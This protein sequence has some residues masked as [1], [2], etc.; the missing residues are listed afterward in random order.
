MPKTSNLTFVV[1][2]NQQTLGFE[3]SFSDL[4]LEGDDEVSWES[5]SHQDGSVISESELSESSKAKTLPRTRNT[6]RTNKRGLNATVL[7]QLLIDIE[8]AG[9]LDNFSLAR[10]FKKRPVFYADKSIQSKARYKVAH[11]KTLPRQEFN[12]ILADNGISSPPRVLKE[13]QSKS[14]KKPPLPLKSTRGALETPSTSPNPK[15]SLRSVGRGFP[16]NLYSPTEPPIAS[17]NPLHSVYKTPLRVKQPANMSNASIDP[18]EVVKKKPSKVAEMLGEC[19]FKKEA[20]R[21]IAH[22]HLQ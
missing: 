6:F 3:E 18:A 2:Q 13:I 16:Q 10:A 17:R 4:N 20:F 8:T 9:G 19:R 12:R 21:K 5:S 7:K 22:N 1:P 15:P 14:S 11:W